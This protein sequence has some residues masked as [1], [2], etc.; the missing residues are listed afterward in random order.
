MRVE[1]H[2]RSGTLIVAVLAAIA[3]VG[4]SPDDNSNANTPS[5]VTLTTGQLQHIRI[6][7]V[8]VSDF[9]KTVDANGLVDFDNDRSTAILAPISGPVSRILVDLGTRV[10]RG[11]ALAE[12]E[13]PDYATAVTTYRKT[14]AAARNA[15]RLADLDKDLLAHASISAREASQAESDAVGAESDR[16]AAKQALVALDLDPAAIRS[17]IAGRAVAHIVGTIR[18]PIAGTVVERQIT[19][20]TLLQAGTTPCFTVA[21]L[22]RVW[23]MAQIF[24][25]DLEHVSV[26]DPVTIST[27]VDGKPLTGTVDNVG[28]VVDPDTR[29]VSVRVVADNPQGLLKKAMYVRVTIQDRQTARGLLV[30]V[31]SILRDDENLPF[32]YVREKDGS[33][34]RRHVTPGYRAGDRTEIE[35]GLKPGERIVADGAIFLQFMQSQ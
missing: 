31:S 14:D 24:G 35:T 30:P 3:L 6:V 32:V 29:S 34:A 4:C 8:G 26:G 28:S 23:V 33:F 21:E 19:P 18:A 17:V 22:S 13:S 2:I 15:R 20:G 1:R 5:N 27:G 12:V 25:S 9:H 10:A 7:T 11:A 16:D